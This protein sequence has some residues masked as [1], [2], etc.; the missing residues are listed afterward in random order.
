MSRTIT[1][2]APATK[3]KFLLGKLTM[4][5]ELGRLFSAELE[6]LSAAGDQ[7][8]NALLGKDITVTLDMEEHGKKFYHGYIA[9]VSQAPASGRFYGYRVRLVPWLWFLTLAGDCRIYQNLTAPEIIEKILREM[10]LTDF[11]LK[12]QHTY[13]RRDICIQYRETHWQFISRLME[14]EGIYFFTEHQAGKHRVTFVDAIT[15]HP[16]IPAYQPIEFHDE[17]GRGTRDERVQTWSLA[18]SL[19]TGKVTLKDF[20]YLKSK[21][22]HKYDHATTAKHARSTYERYDYP[23]DFTTEKELGKVPIYGKQYAQ[24]AQEAFD[25]GQQRISASGDA[26]HLYAGGLFKLSEHPRKDQNAEYLVVACTHELITPEYE[27]GKTNKGLEFRCAFEALPSRTPFRLEQ[28]TAHP[29]IAGTQTAIVCGPP[30]EEIWTDEHG[31]IKLQFHWDRLG[32]DDQNSSCWVRVAQIWAGKSWGAQFLPRVGH[33]VVVS[34]VEGDPDRPLVIGSVYNDVNPVP[35]TLPANKTQSG[36]KSRSSKF[37]GMTDFNEL[38]FED[39]KGME[40]VHLQA[41]KD[42]TELVKHDSTREVDNNET[43]TIKV[44]YT[45]HTGANEKRTVMGNRDVSVTGNESYSI[46]GNETIKTMATM[47]LEALVSITIKCGASSIELT[48]ASI[49]IK[50]PMVTVEG[51]AQLQLKSSGMAELSAPLTTVKG[52]AML[53]LEAGGFAIIKGGLV[54]IN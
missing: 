3:E 36:I 23:G 10:G 30:G 52:S 9:E 21:T 45:H 6:L 28:T 20:D 14:Q 34:F 1:L 12:L 42:Y 17:A 13:R 39:K 26:A 47:T 5:E 11:S 19:K 22:K 38:R 16:K 50:A 15:G 33:E 4:R 25:A 43:V 32:K 54:M 27:S 40:E 24:V 8:F 29:A 37:G 7:D 44:N 51:T 53:D 2:K 41:Q 18:S 49:N 48:P 46:T 35:Y 31:R